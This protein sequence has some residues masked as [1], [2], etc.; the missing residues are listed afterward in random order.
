MDDD[1]GGVDHRPQRARGDRAPRR[2]AASTLDRVGHDIAVAGRRRLTSRQRGARGG[3][4]AQRASRRRQAVSAPR[5]RARRA[6]AAA[7]DRR[8]ARGSSAI[9]RPSCGCVA[10]QDTIT[11]SRRSRGQRAVSVMADDPVSRSSRSRRPRAGRSSA[12]GRT[13]SCRRADRRRAR[14][15]RSRSAR[16]AV[17]PA[18]P[19]VLGHAGVPAV[20]RRRAT[21]RRSRTAQASAEYREVGSG[22]ARRHRARFFTGRRRARCAISTSWSATCHETEVL[23]DDRPIPFARELWLPLVWFQLLP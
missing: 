22:A 7:L 21:T 4:L 6:A 2:A 10:V 16:G 18:R 13:S 19:A 3:R 11:T 1:A 14:G 15:A 20:R 12:S 5:A 17:R 23:I 8:E 9:A